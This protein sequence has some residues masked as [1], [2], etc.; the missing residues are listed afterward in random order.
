MNVEVGQLAPVVTLAN[1]RGQQTSLAHYW[2]QSPAV[3]FFVR[4]LG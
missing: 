3:L 4:H 1:Q 2:E